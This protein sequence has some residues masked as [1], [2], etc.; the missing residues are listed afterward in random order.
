MPYRQFNDLERVDAD[1]WMTYVMNQVIPTFA[2]STER[3]AAITSPIA[4]QHAYI[5]G[6]QALTMYSGSGWV[7]VYQLVPTW[8]SISLASGWVQFSTPEAV[9]WRHQA[10]EI[11]LKGTVKKSSGSIATTD[12]T[13]ILTLPAGAL[14][15]K[16][17]HDVGAISVGSGDPP[18]AQIQIDTAGNLVAYTPVSCSWLSLD[19]VRFPR[20]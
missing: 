11:I 10:G 12:H 16:T 7:I 5:S 9:G 18:L 13:T 8:N 4:G 14:P 3:D 1:D 20:A 15:Q 2:T 17:W 6:S 19:G